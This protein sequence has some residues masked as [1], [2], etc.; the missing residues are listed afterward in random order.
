MLMLEDEPSFTGECSS[1]LKAVKILNKR[2]GD[3]ECFTCG[4]PC[5]KKSKNKSLYIIEN[6]VNEYMY[7]SLGIFCKDCMLKIFKLKK[8]EK[9]VKE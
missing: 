4:F 7:H 2:S 3:I 5:K 6:R 9:E 1:T 8:I